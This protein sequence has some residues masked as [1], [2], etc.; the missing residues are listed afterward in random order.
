M[1][2][3]QKNMLTSVLML[4]FSV[5]IAPKVPAWLG[6]PFEMISLAAV[7]IWGWRLIRGK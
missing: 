7:L 5:W 2:I 4:G 6:I 3:T 1:T